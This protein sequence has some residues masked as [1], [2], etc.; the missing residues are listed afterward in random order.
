M[1]LR[2]LITA[3]LLAASLPA[4]AWVVLD[5]R[6]HDYGDRLR[7]VIDMDRNLAVTQSI[8]YQS[9][10][11][12][13]P[14]AIRRF[15]CPEHIPN[16]VTIQHDQNQIRVIWSDSRWVQAFQLTSPPRQVIDL[17]RRVGKESVPPQPVSDLKDG[18]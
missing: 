1:H 13:Y 6:H 10:T 14:E 9:V 18:C 5:V 2:H 3:I 8:D 15:T 11:L 16:G 17:Y 7:L 4:M 12:G